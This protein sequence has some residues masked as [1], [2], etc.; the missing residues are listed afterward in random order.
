MLQ[1]ESIL[2]VADNSG[3]KELLIIRSLSG[4]N[5]KTCGVGDYVIATIKKANPGSNVKKGDVVM[6]LIVSTKNNFCRPNGKGYI[7]FSKNC[8]VLVEKN[9]RNPL[10]TRIFVPLLLEFSA[11]NKSLFSMASDIL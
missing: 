3:A 8:A 1:N 5:R 6:A 7:K 9:T 2:V 4:S 11:W 10:G